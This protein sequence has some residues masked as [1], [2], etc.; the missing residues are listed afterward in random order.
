MNIKDR[1]KVLLSELKIGQGKFEEICG[2]GNGTINN[3]KLGISSPN[4]E[5][6]MNVF[7]Q[8]NI[9]WLISGR[10]EMFK[11][12]PVQEVKKINVEDSVGMKEV[13]TQMGKL[14]DTNAKQQH[15]IDE[16]SQRIDE[17]SKKI[18]ELQEENRKIRAR[19]TEVQG[20]R[21][22]GAGTIAV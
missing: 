12:S 9:E 14:I 13:F 20:D 17:Q 11:M 18:D 21:A 4:L 5:K 10:G 1:F 6:I 15:R 8:V 16:Q 22:A 7:P 2:M 19:L 3:I